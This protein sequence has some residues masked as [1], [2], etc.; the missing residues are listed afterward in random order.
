MAAFIQK[1]LTKPL[2]MIVVE[3]IV[4]L[5]VSGVAIIIELTL[6]ADHLHNLHELCLWN[7]VS[8]PYSLSDLL[9]CHPW[10]V[11]R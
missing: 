5:S 8:H 4:S 7:L 11:L 10:L 6:A 2:R 1:Y 3:P 9:Y